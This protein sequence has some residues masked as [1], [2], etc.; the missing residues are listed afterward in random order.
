[1][2][3]VS[4]RRDRTRGTAADHRVDIVE[5]VVDRKAS[6]GGAD[7]AGHYVR[8]PAHRLRRGPRTVRRQQ[9]P[10]MVAHR[11]TGRRRLGIEHVKRRA[12]EV[13]AV[14]ESQQRALVDDLTARH[15]DDA[16]ATRQPTEPGG[17]KQAACLLSKRHR[18]DQDVHVPDQIVKLLVLGS[19]LSG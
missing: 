8:D 17:V 19:L 7:I 18:Y 15:L 3:G 10:R 1:M 11:V 12:G 5:D 4:R 13:T 14:Q 6:D 2:P 16:A 9:Y